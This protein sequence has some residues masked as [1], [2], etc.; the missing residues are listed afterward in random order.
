VIFL[1]SQLGRPLKTNFLVFPFVFGVAIFWIFS[2]RTTIDKMIDFQDTAYDQVQPIA[3]SISYSWSHKNIDIYNYTD[4]EYNVSV[5]YLQLILG[6][7][8]IKTIY[9]QDNE[10]I[11]SGYYV[12]YMNDSDINTKLSNLNKLGK[13][14]AKTDSLALYYIN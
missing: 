7:N 6:K 8:S 13:R 10:Y 2:S 4:S 1:I 14:V 9:A 11:P 3:N 12:V 5:L